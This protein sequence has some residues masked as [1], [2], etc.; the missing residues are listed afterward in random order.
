[1]LANLPA[2]PGHEW[3]FARPTDSYV[4]NT[5]DRRIDTVCFEQAFGIQ[6]VAQPDDN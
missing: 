3:C 6:K 4:S 1:M 5:Y 2:Q